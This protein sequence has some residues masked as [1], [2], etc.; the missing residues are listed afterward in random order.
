[1]AVVSVPAPL[2]ERLGD[3]AS[4][5]LV[6]ML[7][8]LQD[9]QEEHLF[10]LLDERFVRHVVEPDP[11]TR[12]ELGTEI[13]GVRTGIVEFRTEVAAMRVDLSKEI[14]DMRKQI[15][16]RTRWILAATGAVT[17]LIPIL[18]RIMSALIP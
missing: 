6:E 15:I 3:A 13:G 2:R 14:A 7:R 17:V 8:Q 16:V 18:Q 11:R 4:A 9:D 10:Q 12:K 5:A 1:M